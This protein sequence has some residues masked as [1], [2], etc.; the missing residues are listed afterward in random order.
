MRVLML[1]RPTAFIAP[2]G[3]VA[4]MEATRRH[5]Q[6]LGHKVEVSLATRPD[7]SGFDVVHVFNMQSGTMPHSFHQIAHAKK[8]NKPVVLSTIYW[9]HEELNAAAQ[10]ELAGQSSVRR[11]LATLLQTPLRAWPLLAHH[12]LEKIRNRGKE[13]ERQKACLE[14]ADA[15]LPNTRAEQ[16]LL[17]RDFGVDEAKFHIIPNAAEGR[18]Y[19]ADPAPFIEKFG[20]RDFVLC[21]ARIEPRKNQLRLLE[22]LREL[23]L[24]GA[25]IGK[26]ERSSPYVQACLQFAG[27]RVLFLDH[28]PHAE[29]APAYAAAKVHA[30]AS[31]YETPGLSNLEAALAGANIVST[32]RGGTREYFEEMAFY[33]EPDDMASIR[34]AVQAAFAKDKDT[35][36]R[37]HIKAHFTWEHVAALTAEIYQEVLAFTQLRTR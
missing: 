23:G 37:A 5:L 24:P 17:M 27:P 16:E 29:L 12:G 30:L 2:G 6:S 15:L 33:C 13:F 22:V 9:T 8:Q 35:C 14:V 25:F 31:W 34:T 19:R 26:M 3:D 36:M 28:L 20:M 7:V 11:R 21:V 10:A 18:F 4:Q 32:S 1:N